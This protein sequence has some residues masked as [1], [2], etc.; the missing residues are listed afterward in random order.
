MLSVF[1]TACGCI[2]FLV[3][4]VCGLDFAVLVDDLGVFGY[5]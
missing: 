2:E 4:L 1:R 3:V 5:V